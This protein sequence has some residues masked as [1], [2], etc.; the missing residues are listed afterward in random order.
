MNWTMGL[1][2]SIVLHIVVVGLFVTMGRSAPSA[3][4]EPPETRDSPAEVAEAETER[5]AFASPRTEPSRAEPVR[6]AHP[7]SSAADSTAASQIR[8]VSPGAAKIYV[9]QRGDNASRIAQKHGLTLQELAN[10]NDTTVRKLNEI[11]IGQR[12]KVAE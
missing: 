9:V 8:P 4:I 11:D 10:L 1:I 6:A 2:G 7:L 3:E 12:L 5:P